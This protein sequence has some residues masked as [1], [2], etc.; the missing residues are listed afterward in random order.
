MT[1]EEFLLSCAKR[2]DGTY[3]YGYDQTRPMDFMC[4]G[5]TP[6]LLQKVWNAAIASSLA[7]LDAAAEAAMLKAN[8][9]VNNQMV[10]TK[11][12]TEPPL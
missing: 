5:T 12:L 1:F 4:L 11:L 7:A 6:Q 10:L 3:P 2:E 8:P 9:Y